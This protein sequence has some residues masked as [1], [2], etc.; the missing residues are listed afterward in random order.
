VPSSAYTLTYSTVLT[1]TV[2]YFEEFDSTGKVE[3]VSPYITR[4]KR[5]LEESFKEYATVINLK[6]LFTGI[7][8]LKK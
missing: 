3:S 1:S 6:Q 5:S 7:I 2:L 4:I 8:V